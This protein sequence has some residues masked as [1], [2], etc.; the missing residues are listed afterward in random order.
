METDCYLT[1]MRNGRWEVAMQ[2]LDSDIIDAVDARDEVIGTVKRSEVFTKK[3][4][5][6]VVHAF[7]FNPHGALLLQRIAAHRDRHPL[8]WGSSV[9]GYVLAGESYDEAIRRKTRL[10]LG[11]AHL[12]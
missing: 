10:E 3:I 11:L 7:V 5:F 2:V 12:P 4:G 1:V 6:R 9:A 8:Q